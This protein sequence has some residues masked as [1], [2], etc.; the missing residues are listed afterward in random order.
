MSNALERRGAPSEMKPY[1][2]W[3]QAL[4]PSPVRLGQILSFPSC[5]SGSIRSHTYRSWVGLCH[6]GVIYAA[7]SQKHVGGSLVSELNQ[8]NSTQIIAHL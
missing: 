8:G 5:T 3:G 4:E 7:S 6:V 2:T 1:L